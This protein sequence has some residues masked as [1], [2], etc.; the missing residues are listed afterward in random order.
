MGLDEALALVCLVAEL[1]RRRF[2]AF[3]RRFLA[4]VAAERRLTVGELDVAVTALRALPSARAAAA[5]RALL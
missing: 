2:D 5:L 4:R 1:D 3:G